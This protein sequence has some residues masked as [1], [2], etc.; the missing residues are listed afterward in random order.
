ML[1]LRRILVLCLLLGMLILG[2]LSWR[3]GSSRRQPRETPAPTIIK[4]PA[5]FANRT[6]DPATPPTDMPPLTPGKSRGA[7]PI[8]CPPPVSAGSLDKWMPHT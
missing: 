6:F 4:Q 8:S 5:S 1:S 2:W 7:I 3:D